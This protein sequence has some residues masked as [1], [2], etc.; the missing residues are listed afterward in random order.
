MPFEPGQLH[1]VN[2]CLGHPLSFFLRDSAYLQGKFDVL[3]ESQPRKEIAIL[4]NEPD[5]CVNGRDFTSFVS[6]M[7]FVRERDSRN[8]FQK[9]AFTA[10][11]RPDDR[12]KRTLFYW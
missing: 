1:H 4:G 8:D 6:Q 5:V 3:D 11:T 12:R 2:K 10:P 9:R 7:S